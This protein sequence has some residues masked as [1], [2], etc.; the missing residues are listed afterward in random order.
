MWKD[1]EM[2]RKELITALSK[3]VEPEYLKYLQ[4]RG[5]DYCPL[6]KAI[7][8]NVARDGICHVCSEKL[9]R[10][11]KPHPVVDEKRRH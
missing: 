10:E 3:G 9:E 1:S 7:I 11:M 5:Y 8:M 2:R 4:L 6:C